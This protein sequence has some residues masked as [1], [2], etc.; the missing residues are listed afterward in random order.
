MSETARI[1]IVDDDDAVRSSL[2]LLLQSAGFANVQAYASAREFLDQAQ[3][4]AGDCLLLDVR[5]PDMDGLELQE[6]LNARGINMP[7]IVMTGD[8]DVPIAVRAMKAGASD[9]LEKPFSDEVLTDCVRSATKRAASASRENEETTGIRRRL[10]TLT[11]RERD[12]LHGMIAGRPNKVIAYDLG[13]SPR[14]VEI[15][16]ARV[17]EKMR[18]RSLSGIIRMALAVGMAADTDRS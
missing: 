7:I 16:R 17:M 15:H 12:V 11:P 13:I 5:M 1:F 3:P 2:H 8:G 14:T 4:Q 10:D 9:F 18:A 6:V